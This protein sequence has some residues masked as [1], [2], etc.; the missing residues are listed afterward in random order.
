V[1]NVARKM[2]VDAEEA[3]RQTCEKFISRFR[4]MEGMAAGEGRGLADMET[5]EMEALWRLAKRAESGGEPAGA[6]DEGS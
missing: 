3:L 1:V 4:A 2:G 6:T 5:D